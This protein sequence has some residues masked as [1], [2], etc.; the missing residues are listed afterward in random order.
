MLGRARPSSGAVAV[1]SGARDRLDP[2]SWSLWSNPAPALVLIV[3]VDGLAVALALVVGRSEP[4]RAADV[5]VFALLALGAV[6][7]HEVSRHVERLREIDAEGRAYVDLKSMWTFAGLLLLPIGLVVLTFAYFWLRVPGRPVVHRWVFSAAAVVLATVAAHALLLQMSTG[8]PDHALD[9]PWALLG[10]T[11]A[12]LLRWAVNLG[13]VA[14]VLSLSAPASRWPDRL[15]SPTDNLLVFGALALGTVLAELARTSPWL[16]PVLLLPLLTM[17]R[18]FLVHQ[19]ARAAHT[20]PKTGLATARHWQAGATRELARARRR[21][22]SLG[23]LMLDL[24]EFKE[25]NDTWGHLAGDRVLRAV[26]E[27][28]GEEVRLEDSVGRFGGEEFVVLLDDL[29]RCTHAR[30]RPG[31]GCPCTREGASM[32]RA[33]ATAERL[34]RRVGQVAVTVSTVGGPRVVSGLS[35]SIGVAVSPDTATGLD[36]LVLAADTALYEAKHSGRD[37]VC[38]APAV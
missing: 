37:R 19:L 15:G 17:H 31:A 10:V 7:H 32:A 8:A 25:V 35:V 38:C 24:D 18:G 27:A 11:L 3:L 36:D 26:A 28:L 9:G 34:R 5:G 16:I 13:L 2:R 1:L 23:V 4:V 21:H 29:H 30:G 33:A 12:G 14:T 20:D 6:V 22:V